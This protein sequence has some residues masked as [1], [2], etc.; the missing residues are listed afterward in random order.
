MESAGTAG[1]LPVPAVQGI[2]NSND[3]SL[4]PTEKFEGATVM[5]WNSLLVHCCEKA[6][7]LPTK[8]MPNWPLFAL[9][10]ATIVTSWAEIVDLL[11]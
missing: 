9:G 1:S 5:T 10:V 8:M 7:P 11:A 4:T 3:A 2:M 6:R